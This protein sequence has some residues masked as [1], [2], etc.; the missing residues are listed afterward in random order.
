MFKFKMTDSPPSCGYVQIQDD[1][2]H[3]VCYGGEIDGERER[4]G[5]MGL[6]F[7][8]NLGDDKK[9]RKMLFC[10]VPKKIPATLLPS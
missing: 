3:R 7:A 10:P 8:T 2:V 9:S 5:G 4:V 1:G 6:E